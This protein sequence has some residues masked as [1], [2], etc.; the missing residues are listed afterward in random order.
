MDTA[1]LL[2]QGGASSGDVGLTWNLPVFYDP[3]G[4]L[5]A[6]MVFLRYFCRSPFLRLPFFLSWSW[7]MIPSGMFK[8]TA[9]GLLLCV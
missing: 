5:A 1:P 8:N 9:Q 6:E 7:L 4:S 3:V 2:D